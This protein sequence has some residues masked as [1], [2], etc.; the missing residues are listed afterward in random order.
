[1]RNFVVVFILRFVLKK[2]VKALV[3]IPVWKRG[4]GM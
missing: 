1:M 3:L 4:L 2:A